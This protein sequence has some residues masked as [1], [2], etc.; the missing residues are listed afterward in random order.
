M[1]VIEFV[2]TADYTFPSAERHF[3][4]GVTNA[5][6]TSVRTLL[7]QLKDRIEMTVKTGSKVIPTTGEMGAAVG[8]KSHVIWTVDP[9]RSEGLLGIAK[10]HLRP[11][12]FHELNHVVRKQGQSKAALSQRTI[13]DFV[14]SE[15]LATAFER[16]EGGRQPPWGQYPPEAQ[17]WVYELIALPP[18]ASFHHWMFRHPDGRRW[19]GYRAGTYVVDQAVKVSG[20]SPSELVEMPTKE[21]F[22]LASFPLST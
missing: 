16:D 12:L 5:A 21:I 11:M 17:S 10:T 4:Q 7:P 14:A 2:D 15:G 9:S 6:E 22:K 8:Q 1:I 13:L 18:D 19:I 20:L 3:I